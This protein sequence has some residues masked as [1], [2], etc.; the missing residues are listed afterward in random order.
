MRVLLLCA[1][2]GALFLNSCLKK[3]SGCSYGPSST[4][5]PASEQQQLKT[6][7]DSAGISATKDSR[8][9]YYDIIK[10]GADKAPEPCSQITV[11]YK[12]QLTNDS[13]FDQKSKY[14][15]SSLGSLI[16]GWRQ[17]LPLIKKGGEIKLYIPPSLGYGSSSN[18]SIPA[19]SILIFDITLID[20]Q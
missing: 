5:A 7:L 16:D 20:V 19:N 2:A 8:G 17:G 3:D 14:V 12:G 18:S 10:P 15:F 13:V 6:W 9:F 1:L 4:V 11:S